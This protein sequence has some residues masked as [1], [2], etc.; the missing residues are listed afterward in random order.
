MASWLQICCGGEEEE[1]FGGIVDP[2]EFGWTDANDRSK[3]NLR[4][5]KKIR[6]VE[7]QISRFNKAR[8]KSR[9]VIYASPITLLEAQSFIFPRFPKSEKESLFIHDVLMQNFIFM[10]LSTEECDQFVDAM[11]K[12]VVGPGTPIITQGAIGD[13]FY[14]IESGMVLY[15]DETKDSGKQVVGKAYSGSSFGE[16]ALLYDCPRAVSCV[17]G[18]DTQVVLWKVDQ[19]TFRHLVARQTHDHEQEMKDL[20]R[21]IDIFKNL[22]DHAITKFTNAMTPVHWEE[23]A[24]IVQKG[25][26]GNVFYIIESGN[27]K[28]HDIGLGDSQFE[29]QIVGPGGWFGER[30]LLTG[31]HRAANVTAM[32]KVTTLAMDR[33]T[34]EA[35]VGPLKNFLELEMKRKFIKSIPIFA[36]SAI[37]DP[38]IN[39]LVNMIQEACYKTG[40]KLVE[41]GKPYPMNLW[42]IRHGRLLVLSQKHETF[43]LESGDYFGDKSVRGDPA[44]ISSHSAVCEE[45]LTTWVLKRED[46]ESV[47]GD[48]NRLGQGKAL[49]KTLQDRNILLSDLDKHR[50][51]GKGAFG[52]VWLVS[53]T[54]KAG[55]SFALKSIS[56]RTL[57]ESKQ[58]QSV[59]NEK[60]FLCLLQHPFILNLVASFQDEENVYLLLPLVPGGELFNVLQKQKQKHLGL[61][62]DHAAFYS[63][64]TIEAI[65]HLHQR[66]IAYRD[67]KLENILIDTEGY[68]K[69]IDLGFAKV[70]VDKTYTLVGTPEYL[71]PEII[72]S[73][74]HDKSVDYWSYGVLVYELLVGHS[75]FYLKHSSQIDMFKRIVMQK[76]TIPE[77]VEGHA[78]VLIQDLLIRKP[79]KRLGNLSKG[80]FDIKKHAWFE[81]SKIKFR[82]LLKKTLEAP[83]K[84]HLTGATDSSNFD[85]FTPGNANSYSRRLTSEEQ[86]L[87]KGF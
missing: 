48:I 69:I 37:T 66:Q 65:G 26:E 30:A 45:N 16:L 7:E 63:A 60:E 3:Q 62:N 68:C 33:E 54:K 36:E 1:K 59:I 42:I 51:L 21:K 58:E 57:L 78:R 67:L 39:Q 5:K 12:E 64:C 29:D 71:A 27:V 18:P 24:R 22:E 43:N 44:H 84:P 53:D 6:V 10:D 25:D 13:Y 87:F 41:P 82:A 72:L 11:Q 55:K 50:V 17:A 79:E 61:V 32:S 83:W 23:G 77:T 8:P 2:E 40:E 34:F 81:M 56:K 52:E 31:E 19:N 15:M 4:N 86:A 76:Y 73:K 46:I 28:I 85:S 35:T 47:I 9:N 74:G 20:V 38:E 49:S 70:V 75:P 80:Y 14:I